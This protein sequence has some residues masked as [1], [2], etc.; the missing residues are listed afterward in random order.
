M[1][2]RSLG[3]PGIPAKQ[4]CE[5]VRFGFITDVDVQMY[6]E[7]DAGIAGYFGMETS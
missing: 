7:W 3:G 2:R 1:I 6:K 5:S 4:A